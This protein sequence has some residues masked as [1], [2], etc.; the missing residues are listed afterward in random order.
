MLAQEVAQQQREG[1]G[2]TGQVKLPPP[3]GKQGAGAQETRSPVATHKA[4]IPL[5]QAEEEG[6]LA[7]GRAALRLVQRVGGAGT[8]CQK[9]V[10][11][12]LADCAGSRG[13]ARQCKE[14]G[15]K[16]GGSRKPLGKQ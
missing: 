9:Q 4:G 5:T 16:Q 8:P 10:R 1:G 14:G 12:E 7:E 15:G 2:G 6:C 3:L 13:W 11:G